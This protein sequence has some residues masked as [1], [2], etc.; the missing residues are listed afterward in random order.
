MEEFSWFLFWFEI[1]LQLSRECEAL[2]RNKKAAPVT[3]G[4]AS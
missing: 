4:A 2:K 1:Q 3:A